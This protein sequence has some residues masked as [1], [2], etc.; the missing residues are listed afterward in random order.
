MVFL[1]NTLFPFHFS[2]YFLMIVFSLIAFA[3]FASSTLFS[4]AVKNENYEVVELS[5]REFGEDVDQLIFVN[6]LAFSALGFASMRKNTK[7]VKQLLDLKADINSE[8]LL[9]TPL[10]FAAAGGDFEL[11]QL[12]VE[13]KVNVNKYSEFFTC[14]LISAIEA[15]EIEIAE[16][17]IDSG[18]RV[19]TL[20]ITRG[21]S[22][23]S[24]LYYEKALEL[25]DKKVEIL[26]L[27]EKDKFLTLVNY[28]IPLERFNEIEIV[29]M[30]L[31]L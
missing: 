15:S 12:L 20:S 1:Y 28:L 27:R 3:R 21:D 14:P 5:I 2:Q 4:E 17:L 30:I 29:K 11:C 31:N 18:A 22:L 10:Y 23:E 9:D 7:M 6:G 24:V 8:V 26:R 25:L 19:P 13:R 16:F